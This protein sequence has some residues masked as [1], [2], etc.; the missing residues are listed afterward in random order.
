MRKIKEV[1]AIV[2]QED[3]IFGRGKSQ[4]LWIRNGSIRFSGVQRCQD[5][6]SQTPKLRHNCK[7]NV[8]VRIEARH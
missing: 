3:S 5:I 8:L 7:C 2:R 6:M 4:N 1:A